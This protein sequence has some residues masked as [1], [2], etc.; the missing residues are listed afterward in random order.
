MEQSRIEA[1]T[2]WLKR[3]TSADGVSCEDFQLLSGG[4]I[5]Q[6]WGF[7]VEFDGGS[8][9]GSHSLILRTDP[10][11][12]LSV[13]LDRET[14]FNVLKTVR[15]A[16]V[17]VPEPLFADGQGKAFDMPFFIMRRCS[18]RADPHWL[19]TAEELE[20]NRHDIATA[21]GTE[22][23]KIHS[24]LPPVE[25]LGGLSDTPLSPAVRR[26]DEFRS[27]LDGLPDGYPAVEWG[28][29][30]LEQ[31]APPTPMRTLTH[32]DFR[33]GNFLV[34]HGTLSAILDWEFADWSDPLEDIG[35]FTAR[36]WRYGMDECEAGGL[37]PGG[38]FISAYEAASGGIVD[39]TMIGYWQVLATV[40]WTIIALHQGQ[41]QHDAGDASLE[42]L[43][44]GRKAAE[45][46]HEILR[47]IRKVEDSY[48]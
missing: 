31:Y 25:N 35:W 26:I 20:D 33:T 17:A 2:A 24:I 29:N 10:Y 36:C 18:G 16:G 21:L 32:G 38:M 37:A 12:P 34:Y 47:L 19:T 23:G 41:R 28:I 13:G 44:T 9:P 15:D 7:Q 40:R 1:L 11:A 14:E 8:L 3:Q 43:L 42:L 45:L 39:R 4:A 48:V 27:M 5:Q 46:E 6:N 30:W 22:L